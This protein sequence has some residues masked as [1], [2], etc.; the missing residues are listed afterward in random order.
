VASKEREYKKYSLEVFSKILLT[1]K[2]ASALPNKVKSFSK[3]LPV[4]YGAG[5]KRQHVFFL[6]NES[7]PVIITLWVK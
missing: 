1:S 7:L 2:F 3:V 6:N 5:M 4:S